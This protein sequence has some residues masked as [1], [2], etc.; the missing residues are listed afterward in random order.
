MNKFFGVY[1]RWVGNRPWTALTVLLAVTVVAVI[2]LTKT[3]DPA[4]VEDAFLP[5]GSELV[6]AID[7]LATSFPDSAEL[8]VMQVVLR[9]DVLSPAGAA[10]AAAATNAAAGHPDL[11]EY[12]FQAR[13]PT[14][15]GHVLAAML[16]GPEGDFRTVDLAA[17][18]QQEID[19]AVASDSNAELAALLDEMVARNDSGSVIGGVG[20][21]TVNAYG[22]PDG[23]AEAQLAADDAVKQVDLRELESARAAS[24]GKSDQESDDS[25]QS[26]LLVLMLVA[27]AVIAL[28]LVLFYRQISDVLLSLGGLILTILWALGFQGLLGPDGL[29]VI[30]APSVLAQMVPVMLIGLCVDYGIQVTSR[31]REVRSQG[32]DAAEGVSKSVA[33]VMLP[34]GL[35][36][37]T[38]IASFLTNVFGDISGLADFG[39]VAAVG[40]FSGLTVFLTAV[41]AT[42]SLLDRRGEAKG[43]SPQIRPIDQAIPGAGKLVQSIGSATVRRPSA[44][45]ASTGIV[46]VVFMALTTQLGTEF[47]SND[48]LPDGTESKEDAVFMAENL[49]GNT[50]PVTV[51]VEADLSNDRTMRNLLDFSSAIEDPSQRPDAVSSSITNSLGA[52]F[53]SLPADLQAQ[54]GAELALDQSSPLF[55]DSATIDDMLKSMRDHDPAR[56]DSVV[57]LGPAGSDDRTILQFNALTGDT[58]RTRELFADVDGLWFGDDHDITP[59]ANEITSLEVTD[60]LTESQ[61][62]SIMLTIMAALVVLALFFWITEF[63]PMLAVLSVL[64]ILLVLVWV[65]GT[66]VLLGYSY[67]V[68]TALITA[69]SIG[70]GVDYTIHVTHRFI[71][72][73]DHGKSISEAINTTMSTTGGALIGSALTTALGFMVLVFSP[74]APMGQFGL[75]T[76]ITVIYSLVAAVVVLPPMLVVWA[77]YHSWRQQAH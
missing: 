22:D 40:V 4:D 17:A 71:E 72:E 77:A 29:D 68:I 73:V 8:Q 53:W 10:D 39:V 62:T 45:L 18:S 36:G 67:N 14:S 75:L 38:T 60:S 20:I 15:P 76:A 1:G 35:A 55:L 41:P 56:F 59:V 19:A 74:I 51:L 46:T 66:M 54:I 31:Y 57:A 5:E 27:F 2:G 32:A 28:L 47:N 23:L 50:E 65:L 7:N 44:I 33:G 37:V 25:S 26:S 16:A 30:G 70:I 9:G 13:P 58:D 49:G 64:P 48:F 11:A 61:A 6:E 43:K 69:L 3:A 63:R 52:Y 21:V 34:L 24:K 12:L 42:R